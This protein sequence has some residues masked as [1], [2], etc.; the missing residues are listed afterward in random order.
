LKYNYFVFKIFTI[1]VKIPSNV[2][3][4]IDKK[5]LKTIIERHGYNVEDIPN[6]LLSLPFEKTIT[7]STSSP[8]KQSI[9]S[10]FKSLFATVKVEKE[11]KNNY[12]LSESYIIDKLVKTYYWLNPAPF[13]L[14]L[15]ETLMNVGIF[16]KGLNHYRFNNIFADNVETEVILKEETEFIILPEALWLQ[17]LGLDP[18]DVKN[19]NSF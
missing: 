10:E 8:M 1:G 12:K 7:S 4:V 13:Q 2:H 11:Q 18:E 5:N 3:Q 6:K 19:L 15:N 14:D 17:V 9:G 16:L